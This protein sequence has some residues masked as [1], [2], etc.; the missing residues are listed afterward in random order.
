MAKTMRMTLQSIIAKQ[1]MIMKECDPAAFPAPNMV[2]SM[3]KEICESSKDGDIKPEVWSSESDKAE[4]ACLQILRGLHENVA[5][6]QARTKEVTNELV[7][8]A[9]KLEK[10]E[11]KVSAL[12]VD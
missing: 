6:S 7:G 12:T 8:V 10:V 4:L 5:T 9:K 1:I 3:V 11:S 2:K